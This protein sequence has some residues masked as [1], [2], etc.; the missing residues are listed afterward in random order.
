MPNKFKFWRS[1]AEAILYITFIL[2]IIGAVNVFSA[3]FV[4]A[5]QE[6]HDS[7]YFVK[8]HF[9]AFGIG[10]VCLLLTAIMDYRR[11]KQLIFLLI[12]A[13]IGFLIAVSVMGITING[14][15]RWVNI[16]FQ[17][18][19]SE[20]AKLASVIIAASYLGP[21]VEKQWRVT[22]LSS[23]LIFVGIM[24]G[25]IM[26]QPDMGTAVLV[27]GLCLIMY[28][29]AGVPQQQ[30]LSLY[31]LVVGGLVY[32]TYAA[33]YRAERIAAW[34]NPWAF[35][36]GIGYQTVQ[37]LLAIGSGGITG[38]GLGMGASKF[39]Y[40]PE[41]HTDFAFAVLCQEMGFIG[42]L[43]VLVLFGAFA[44]YGGKIARMA[45][46][47]FGKMLAIGLTLMI[48]GQGVINISMVTGMLPVIGVPLP[49]ISFGGTSLIV[50]MAAVG[51]LISIGRRGNT[52][53]TQQEREPIAEKAAKLKLIN[54]RSE[55]H[56]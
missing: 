55:Q 43:L 33:S 47:G 27:V 14:A 25:L 41:A 18:Q 31:A 4:S 7:Y 42:A 32:F 9:A 44:L 28:V 10:F 48:V 1:P 22:L 23:P 52:V 56:V 5:G 8:K 35:Q 34:L 54:K 45:T 53:E 36:Q 46:D 16:G 38:T 11:L 37:S 30:R 39:Y 26:K 29:I 13:T 2:L 51:I 24:G 20:V 21:R 17:F 50:N 3:S 40:L 49:F 15:R 6:F 19:P 12:L